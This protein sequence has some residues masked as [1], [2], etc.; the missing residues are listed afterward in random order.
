MQKRNFSF[1]VWFIITLGIV[2]GTISGC[3]SL[4]IKQSLSGEE[5]TLA[6]Q[7]SSAVTFPESYRGNVM[8]VGYVYTHCPD[9]CPM[10][11]YNMRDVQRA[12]PGQSDFMLVSV[13]F[14]PDRDTPEILKDYAQ[15]YR[16]DESNWRLLTG[17]KSDVEELLDAL[18]VT[19]IKTPT[20]FTE[21]NKPIYF[22]DHTDR[23]TLIDREGNVRKHYLGS[24]F[25]PEEVKEDILKLLNES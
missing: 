18:S 25:K 13:S 22:I 8:L 24:E 16:I 1:Y 5:F 7:D 10:I 9:I 6:D 21:E 11:T 4:S 17:K 19:T 12:L 15:N 3:D 2:L 20:R 14:D 23:V